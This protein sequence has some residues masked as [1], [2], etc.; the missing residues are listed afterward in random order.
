M[1]IFLS[2]TGMPLYTPLSMIVNGVLSPIYEA[3]LIKFIKT[4]RG[5]AWLVYVDSKIKIDQGEAEGAEPVK[6]SWTQIGDTPVSDS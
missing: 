5:D 1:I 2:I 6:F 4:Y 3:G